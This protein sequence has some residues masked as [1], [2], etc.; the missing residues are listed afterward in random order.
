M[1]N[2]LLLFTGRAA[3]FVCPGRNKPSPGPVG[4]FHAS[5][6]ADMCVIKAITCG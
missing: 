1:D 2:G 4:I 5:V 6:I 3:M